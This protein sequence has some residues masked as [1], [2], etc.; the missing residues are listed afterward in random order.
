MNQVKVSVDIVQGKVLR[1]IKPVSG[2]LIQF[3][4]TT[5]EKTSAVPQTT[6]HCLFAKHL[7]ENVTRE[8]VDINSILQD[9]AKNVY[10][11]SNRTQSPVSMNG[12]NHHPQ[13]YLNEV[14]TP[15]PSK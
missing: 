15:V 4:C 5:D 1:E 10:R 11:E 9:V 3:A 12:L 14:I 2:A 6:R 7:L 8:N 13:V